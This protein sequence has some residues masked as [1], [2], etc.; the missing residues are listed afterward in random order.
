[1]ENLAKRKPTGGKRR[2]GRGRRARESDGY[3]VE[4]VVG[5]ALKRQF[6]TRGGGLSV[7]LSSIDFANVADPTSKRVVRS[8]IVRVKSSP[9]NREYER[10]GVITKGSMIETEAGEAR[11]TSRPSD[12]GAVNAVLIKER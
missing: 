9:A 5:P 12:D 3:P 2:R 6:R 7:G 4:T 10:R 11:V 1:M 8:K